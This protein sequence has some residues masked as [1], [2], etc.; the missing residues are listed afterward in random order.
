M[1]FKSYL[2]ENDQTKLPNWT[3]NYEKMPDLQ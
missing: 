2:P 3:N 1:V